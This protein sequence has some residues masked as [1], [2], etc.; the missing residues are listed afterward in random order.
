MISLRP[1]LCASMAVMAGALLLLPRVD[2]L[3]L[4]YSYT[5][6]MSVSGGLVTVIFFTVWGQAF[7]S[8][9]L[10]KIQAAAQ[11]M[12][13]LASSIGPQWLAVGHEQSGSYLTACGTFAAIAFGL[14]VAAALTPVPRAAD[15]IWGQPDGTPV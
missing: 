13:V 15:G 1:L 6:L 12:T 11:M 2:S 8:A 4:V 7:G 9:S 10:G 5:A 3:A 14:A